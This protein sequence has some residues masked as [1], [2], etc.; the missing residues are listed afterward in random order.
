MMRHRTGPGTLVAASEINAATEGI[1]M[2]Y[3]LH[4]NRI[5]Q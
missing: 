2:R 1:S 5:Y 4:V 3:N